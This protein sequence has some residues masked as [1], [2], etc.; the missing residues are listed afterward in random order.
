MPR[1]SA[2]RGIGWPARASAVGTR[3]RIADLIAIMSPVGVACRMAFSCACRTAAG[4]V[5]CRHVV[6]CSAQGGGGAGAGWLD[7]MTGLVEQLPQPA[8]E[9]RDCHRHSEGRHDGPLQAEPEGA[10]RTA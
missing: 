2:H 3:G 6:Y 9:Q 4:R 8:R 5:L 1:V 7:V 10:V